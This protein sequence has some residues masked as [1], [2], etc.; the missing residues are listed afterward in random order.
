MSCPPDTHVDDSSADAALC[1]GASCDAGTGDLET[2]CTPRE[3]CSAMTC[4][5][6]AGWSTDA[7]AASALCIGASCD[8]GTDDLTT[9]CNEN[10][11]A[12]IV[13]G[14]GVV[15]DASGGDGCTAGL[16]LSTVTDPSCAV[17][18]DETTHVAQSGTVTCGSASASGA[19]TTEQPSCVARAA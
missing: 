18:C 12:A 13:L 14:T 15:S 8:A 11:C 19:A 1:I 3:A 7:D 9:C 16:E 5:A 2:C 4:S 10:S 17:K 6:S